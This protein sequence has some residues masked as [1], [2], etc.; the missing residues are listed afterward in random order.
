MKFVDV[1]ND[2]AF[3]L[4]V[5]PDN[6]N[7]EG[8]KEACEEAARHNWTR[9]EYDAYISE[10]SKMKKAELKRPKNAKEMK[11]S[12]VWTQMGLDFVL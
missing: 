6:V 5:M 10:E 7:D 1:K 9:E 2:I 12:L 3:K 4:E 8:L 11:W